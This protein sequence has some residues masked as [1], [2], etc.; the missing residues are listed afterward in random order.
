MAPL[1][2]FKSLQGQA[3][4]AP[5]PSAEPGYRIG[6]AAARSGLSAANIRYYERE[7]LLASPARGGNAYRRYSE[8]DLHQLRFIRLC[9]ALDMSLEEVRTLLG[10]D[11]RSKADCARAR[12]TLDEHL[13]HVRERL[14]ELRALERDLRALRDRCDGLDANCHL[15]EALHARADAEADRRA[16]RRASHRHV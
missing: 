16:P 15:I 5:S 9:R 10:L 12:D 3:M 13:G 1:E 14:A 11:L 7:G 6:E 2:T 4:P 8:A